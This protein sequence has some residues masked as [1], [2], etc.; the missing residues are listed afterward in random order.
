[1]RLMLGLTCVLNGGH[2][3]EPLDR[4]ALKH[5]NVF[6]SLDFLLD[7]VVHPSEYFHSAIV[8]YTAYLV[9]HSQILFLLTV[10]SK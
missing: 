10:I 2:L 3:V 4:F 5:G 1:M 6:C 7:Q 9:S 8:L